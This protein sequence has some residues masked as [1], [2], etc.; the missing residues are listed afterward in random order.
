MYHSTKIVGSKLKAWKRLATLGLWGGL[1]LAVLLAFIIGFGSGGIITGGILFL[2]SWLGTKFFSK[3]K[4]KGIIEGARKLR[5]D[6]FNRI[7]G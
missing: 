5:Q 2:V 4:I 6:A 3:A 1:A 7:M